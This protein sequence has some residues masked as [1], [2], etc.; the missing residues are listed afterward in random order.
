MNKA[1]ERENI[2]DIR[3]GDLIEIINKFSTDKSEIFTIVFIENDKGD[4]FFYYAADE[5]DRNIH[6]ETLGGQ[7]ISY[8]DMTYCDNTYI[9]RIWKPAELN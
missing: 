7:Q 8:C 4:I 2:E 9:N 1:I 3:V 6:T 5:D